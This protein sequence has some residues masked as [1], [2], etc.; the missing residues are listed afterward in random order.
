MVELERLVHSENGGQWLYID[1]Y[2]AMC[3]FDQALVGM[4]NQRNRFCNVP[5]LMFR[6]ERLF[7]ID[8]QD[9]ILAGNVAWKNDGEFVPS[10]V[11]A[12]A[13]LFD[14]AARHDGS[15]R[16]A[17]ET[18]LKP[19]VAGIHGLPRDFPDAFFAWQAFTDGLKGVH[20]LRSIQN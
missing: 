18:I 1:R 3:D 20:V 12:E 15:H 6:K 9:C 5:D 2:M 13:D 7:A 11:A 8:Q 14:S 16:P 4:G 19:D 10:Y 17:V